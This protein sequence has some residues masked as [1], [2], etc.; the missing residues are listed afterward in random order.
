MLSADTSVLFDTW[1][2]ALVELIES[3]NSYQASAAICRL[4]AQQV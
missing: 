1:L 3:D 4:M 2:T